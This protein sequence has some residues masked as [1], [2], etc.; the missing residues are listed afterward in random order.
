[1]RFVSSRA[2]VNGYLEGDIVI[3]GA[4]LI[5]EA[6]IIGRNVTVGY[7]TRKKIKS[8]VSAKSFDIRKCDSVSEGSEIG[9]RCIIRS[10]S[11]IYELAVLGDGVET[12]H[13][14][15][16]REVSSVGQGSLIGSST[17]L[18]GKVTVGKNVSVQSNV[19]LPHL[20]VIED[21]VF[22]APNVCLTNDPYPHSSRLAGTVV[23]ENAIICANSTI[24]PGLTIGEAAVVGAGS[25]VTK[26]VPSRS[27]VV[28]SPARFLMSREDFDRK[29]E[30][31]EG[32]SL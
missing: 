2:K 20:T 18:D 9:K 14:V 3:L 27:V 19:Y 25:V 23:D 17:M 24:L 21:G 13:N 22:I 31:W 11:V 29:K 4:T 1:M 15:L 10:G 7:P 12:G 28:G 5:G 6:S 30:M 16:I 26:D 8:L 32:S